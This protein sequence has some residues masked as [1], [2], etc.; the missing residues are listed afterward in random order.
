VIAALLAGSKVKRAGIS[1]RGLY[2]VRN[3]AATP[4]RNAFAALGGPAINLLTWAL[5][6]IFHV[7]HAWVALFIGGFNLM[8]FPHSDLRKCLSYVR[9]AK[10]AAAAQIEPAHSSI[11]KINEVW[12]EARDAA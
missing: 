4:W 6:S 8:P 2:V 11:A 1:M 5:L 3:A 12:L 10:S 7:P 9:D